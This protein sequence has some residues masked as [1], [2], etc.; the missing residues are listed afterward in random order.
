[1]EAVS[2]MRRKGKPPSVP[3]AG[4]GGDVCEAT[5][6]ACGVRA[7]W[8]WTEPSV[9]TE[10]MLTALETGVKGGVWFSLMDKV[11][12][13]GN[14]R[15]SAAKV[16]G[17]KGSAGVDHVTVEAF[18]ADLEANLERL[19]RALRDGSYR[20]SAIRRTMIPKP[21]SRE[22]RPLGIPTV[23]DRVA[24][25][26][27]RQALEP[28]FEKG[29]ADCSYGFRPGRGRK[30]ALRRVDALL[31]EGFTHVVDV[32]I[33]GYFDAIDHLRLMELLKG[34]VADGTVLALVN[35]FLKAGILSDGG[36]WE[37][38][39]GVPQGS[40]LGPLLSNVYLDPLDHLM[41]AKGF[42]MVRY[43]DDMVVPCRSAA[44]AEEALSVIRRWC[45]SAKLELHPE[46]T[47]VVDV[48]AVGFDF[49]GYHFRESKGRVVRWPRQRSLAKLRD[50]VRAKT[51]RKRGDALSEI[52][53]DVNAT[54][55]GWYGYFKHSL[56]PTF[57]AVD[58]WVR[59]RLRCILRRRLGQDCRSRRMDRIKWP[60]VFFADAGLFS[61][62]RAWKSDRQSPPG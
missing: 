38:E 33:K 6:D 2:V 4:Q 17:N 28:I 60:N 49:L 3:E 9:W 55:V 42:R 45:E 57:R 1:M 35:Q 29:F 39:S 50:A 36:E 53:R 16:V 56:G 32:D 19:G 58:G 41:T 20:P 25:G 30:D 12:C 54:L 40:V 34:K 31:K 44:E 11:C 61:L 48:R 18:S 8:S 23:R 13:E 24:Q 51:A 22:G 26:A 43:A 5:A 15:S 37:P 7:R 27:V 21:G 14:L 46:K 10:R 62:E 47:K 59:M 52:V